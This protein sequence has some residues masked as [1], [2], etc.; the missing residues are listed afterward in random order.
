MVDAV[1]AS[2]LTVNSVSDTLGMA[3][4][5]VK[6]NIVNQNQFYAQKVTDIV[7]GPKWH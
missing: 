5:A 6:S 3:A 1:F 2:N 4:N 7:F